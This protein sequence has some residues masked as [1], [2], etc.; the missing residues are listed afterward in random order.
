M[1]LEELI[2]QAFVNMEVVGSRVHEGHY[3]LINKRG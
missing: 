2:K 1:D 3:D